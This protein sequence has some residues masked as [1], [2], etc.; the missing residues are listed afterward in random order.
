MEWWGFYYSG[1]TPPA[2]GDIFDYDIQSNPGGG[3]QP[4]GDI[5][6]GVLGSLAVTDTG[7][8]DQ[9]LFEVYKY[10]ASASV[11]LPAGTYYLSIYDTVS[12]PGNTFAWCES[13]VSAVGTSEW[14]YDTSGAFGWL[15]SPEVGLAFNLTGGAAVPEPATMTLFGLGLAGLVSKL[16]RRKNR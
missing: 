2:S 9:G 8:L 1:N 7:T 3:G 15:G 13:T 12:N 6:S 10:D 4:S 16:A 11:T 5:T 14:S